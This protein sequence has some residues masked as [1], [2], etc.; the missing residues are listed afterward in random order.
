M[1]CLARSE[2][3]EDQQNCGEQ[4][5]PEILI[6]KAVVIEWVGHTCVHI[7]IFKPGTIKIDWYHIS[8]LLRRSLHTLRTFSSELERVQV[9]VPPPLQQHGLLEATHAFATNVEK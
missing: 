5:L 3:S 9:E 8:R 2:G 4:S 6:R 1:G 7:P